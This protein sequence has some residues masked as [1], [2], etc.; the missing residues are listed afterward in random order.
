MQF[1]FMAFWAECSHIGEDFGDS[2]QEDVVSAIGDVQT[3]AD[4][5]S[6]VTV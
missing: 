5:D 3:A 2:H 4:T 6:T 1:D